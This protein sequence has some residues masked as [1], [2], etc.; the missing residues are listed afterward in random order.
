MQEDSR[1]EGKTIHYRRS[2][3]T[4]HLPIAYLYTPSHA[5][6]ARLDP[7]KDTWRV[8]VTKFATRMLGEMVDHGWE[9]QP[10]AAV[11]CGQVIGWLEGFKAISDVFC[12]VQ[13]NFSQANAVLKEKI[14]LVN[15]DC[16]GQGWLYE[17][18][19]TPDSRCLEVQAYLKLLDKTIDRILEKQKAEEIQ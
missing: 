12:V 6:L 19:G 7:R 4:T 1:G 14:T 3:F 15:K 10:G 2:R 11:T 9:V 8:G 13:G 5:W 18:Q 17:A 16:Y